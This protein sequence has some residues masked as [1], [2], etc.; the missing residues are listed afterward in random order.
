MEKRILDALEKSAESI[1]ID[2]KHTKAMKY[3]EVFQQEAELGY[4]NDEIEELIKVLT[5]RGLVD[6]KKQQ[7]RDYLYCV[8]TEINFAELKS[9][10]KRLE[11]LDALAK[12]KGF[13]SE[14]GRK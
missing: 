3:H 12:S 7:G 6:L 9:K 10:F 1:V 13:T 11:A 8:E 2:G 14:T 5:A 4:L